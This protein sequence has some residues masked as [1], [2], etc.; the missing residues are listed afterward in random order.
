MKSTYCF[1]V[2]ALL[3]LVIPTSTHARQVVIHTQDASKTQASNSAF[4]TLLTRAQDEGSVR[5][6][7][8]LDMDVQYARKRDEVLS[9]IDPDPSIAPMQAEVVQAVAAHRVGSITRYRYIPYIALSVT[10]Q[11][12]SALATHPS[13]RVIEE[14]IAVPPAL[15]EST[16][17]INADATS[18]PTF[19]GNGQA[20][21]IIDTGVDKAHSFFGSRV[22]SEACYSTTSGAT[23]T[24]VCPGSVSEST[25]S[26]SG[27]ACDSSIDGCDHGTHVAGIAA[28]DGTSFDGV[29]R[30]SSVIAL[31]V[32]SSFANA[33][34]CGSLSTPCA[35][36]YTSDQVK[37]LERVLALHNDGGFTTP[38]A[39]VNMSLGGSFNFTT[40]AA[41]DVANG[42]RKTAIDNLRTV[43]IATVVSSGNDGFT[44][45][46]TA[47]SCISSAISVGSVGDG[48]GGT[49]ADA[50]S[51]FSNSASFLDL[52][53]PGEVIES[54]VP[55]AS[56]SS[57]TGLKSGTSMAAPHVTGAIAVYKHKNNGANV[58]QSLTAL[59]ATG[60]SVTDAKSSVTTPRIKVD[61]ALNHNGLPV[62]LVSFETRLDGTTIQLDWTTAAEINN[63]G[64][65]IQYRI[66]QP[67]AIIIGR[68]ASSVAPSPISWSPVAFVEGQGT[69]PETHRYQYQI[70][71]TTPGR[72][73]FRLKQI[74][75]AGTFSYSDVLAL[76]L[77]LPESLTLSSNYPNPFNPITRIDFSV[78]T[79]GTAKLTVFDMLGREVTTL[80]WGST[81]ANQQ[82]QVM[83]DGSDFTSGLYLYTLQFGS[84]QKTGTM[85]LLK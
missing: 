67:A 23:S 42:S 6:L 84:Q 10:P 66:E 13:V 74:D 20:V 31:Q 46:L 58:D 73:F 47:P 78:P 41:C 75:F 22:V 11:G 50:A 17:L 69:T 81:Q 28:A 77:E 71:S 2:V 76:T 48:S 18:N 68:P 14:D 45:G 82:Y 65:E 24:S 29:A 55:G 38:I 49:T 60:V 12:L 16:A 1:L 3:L 51:S 79:S 44:N 5:V 37:A 62:E 56:G 30:G 15:A 4:N 8:G 64:F 32:F 85:L 80:F 27:V 40:E 63:A 19:D 9:R 43:G 83:F 39:A 59:Q 26:G 72:Y 36:S 35:L 57:D 61:D 33:S 53:A 7:V 52:L 34:D 21:A 54:S 70:P 25:A